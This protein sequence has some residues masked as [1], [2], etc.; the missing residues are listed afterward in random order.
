MKP[1][2]KRIFDKLEELDWSV[3]IYDVT[4]WEFEKY[5]P[6]GE[7]FIFTVTAEKTE[8][9]WRE[10]QR[11]AIDFDQD[12]HIEMWVKA[13]NSTSG[14]PGIRVLVEDAAEIQKMLDELADALREVTEGTAS[15]PKKE[16]TIDA[17]WVTFTLNGKEIAAF[18]VKGMAPG[19][20]QATVELL[21]Y[22]RGV[23]PS[24]IVVGTR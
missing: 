10:V 7:D 5:S 16:K 20:I 23:A 3:S 8:D 21:A 17:K 19:E 1:I 14:V 9:L 18:T 12:E 15:K 2:K 24:D 11:Y 13:R 4:S 6:A 22:E